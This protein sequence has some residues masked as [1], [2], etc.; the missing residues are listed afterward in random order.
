[1]LGEAA[2]VAGRLSAVTP[3]GGIWITAKTLAVSGARFDVTPLGEKE[4]GPAGRRL[5]AF[6]VDDEG[7]DPDVTQGS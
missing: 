2:E 1:M 4:L 3:G 5:A 7:G 6:S